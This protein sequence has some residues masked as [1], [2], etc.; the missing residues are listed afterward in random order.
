MCVQRLVGQHLS[1][2]MTV[3]RWYNV[4]QGKSPAE[5]EKSRHI[6]HD[7]EQPY[8]YNVGSGA[9]GQIFEEAPGLSQAQLLDRI[10]PVLVSGQYKNWEGDF[11]N[12][13]RPVFYYPGKY[14]PQTCP[15]GDRVQS[16]DLAT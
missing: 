7:S 15:E 11:D 4:G 10:T 16:E 14:V 2:I 9:V 8:C 12:E 1:L 3:T 13:A 5:S 6:G